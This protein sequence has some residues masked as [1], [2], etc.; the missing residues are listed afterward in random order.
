MKKYVSPILFLAAGLI[1]GY[2]FFGGN[3]SSNEHDGHQ[4]E[5]KVEAWTCSMHPQIR[6]PESGNCPI[7]GMDLIP[8]GNDGAG[9]DNP[10]EVK[11]SPTAMQL[12]NVQT[13]VISKKK[14]VKE[15]RLN[16]KIQS[17]E[18][19]VFS[20]T[21]HISGR[22][23]RLLVTYTGEYVSKGQVIAYIYS[24][25]LV[26]AQEELFEAVKIKEQQ[27]AL[28]KAAKEKLKNWKLT[29]KQIENILANGKPTEDFPILSDLN[30][31][32][33]S[34]KINLGDHVKQGSSLFEVANLS[35]VWILFDVYESDLAWVKV[36]NEVEYTVQSFPGETFKGKIS[37]IDPVINPKTRVAKARITAKNLGQRFKPEMFVKGI[38]QNPLKDGK[39]EI[40]VPKSAVMWTGERSVVYLKSSAES[41]I[42]FLMREV[43]LGP[44]LGDQYL[45][46]EGLHEGEEIA[47]YGTF[48]IDAAAQLAGK[49]SMMNPEGGAAMTGHNHGGMKATANS[50]HTDHKEHAKPIAINN[51][52]KKAL[53]PLF[54]AYLKLKDALVSDDL[55]NAKQAAKELQ[56]AHGKVNMSLFKG[57]AH[58]VWMK[59]SSPIKE[60]MNQLIKASDI[61]MVRA[62][63]IRL[64]EQM[65]MLA[66]TFQPN[67]QTIFI[68]YCPMADNNKGANWISLENEVR[69]PY[70]G[71]SMLKCGEVKEELK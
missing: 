21:S 42:G 37:F 19:Y 30:G 38:L 4:H 8:V 51:K 5:S 18:R 64:S 1:L 29:D 60:D 41:G 65:I 26:T 52:A 59:H 3:S 13:A 62:K 46:T 71:A 2:L 20:Q 66:K 23:E 33:T 44:A 17:D 35:R 48:S 16:G 63:F 67:E 28:F 54:E 7:C 36:G 58:D 6:Q 22:I 39:K 53:H 61:K 55:D 24:P 32:V 34:K 40:I 31:V 45:I 27:P 56:K 68:Q 12:A 50:G 14:P 11:M 70:F 25:E 15:V 10:L 43:K 69:N 57:E 47:T 9:D 49:P